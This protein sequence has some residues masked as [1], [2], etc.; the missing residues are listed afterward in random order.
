VLANGDQVSLDWQDP[1]AAVFT[2]QVEQDYAFQGLQGLPAGWSTEIDP[3][4]GAVYFVNQQT[5]QTQ[6]EL[7]Q[8][9]GGY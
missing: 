7:P 9:Q 3:A 5:G 2:C 1:E 4:S 6:W 8:Q